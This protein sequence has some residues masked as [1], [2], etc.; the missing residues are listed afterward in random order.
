MKIVLKNLI[1]LYDVRS[2]EN[3][4]ITSAITAMIGEDLAAALIVDCLTGMGYK[5]V[6]LVD[7]KVKGEGKKGN[8]LDR[9]ISAKK[10]KKKILYQVE[11]KM[12]NSNSVKGN[13]GIEIN[14]NHVHRS[15]QP[16]LNFCKQWDH[17]K[18]TLRNKRCRKVLKRMSPPTD[19][20]NYE[21]KPLI[22]YWAQIVPQKNFKYESSNGFFVKR[23]RKSKRGFKNLSFFSLSLYLRNLMKNGTESLELKLTNFEKRYDMLNKIVVK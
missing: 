11:I 19:Y 1:A 20:E 2:P 22:C 15:V 14:N 23:I 6:K 13:D 17:K 21:L 12:W 9:W 18:K 10:G 4:R 5:D 8:W 16:Y 7:G 3:R